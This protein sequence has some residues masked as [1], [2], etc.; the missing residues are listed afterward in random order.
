[1][2]QERKADDRHDC[3]CGTQDCVLHGRGRRGK[4][5]EGRTRGSA[6]T[7]HAVGLRRGWWVKGAKAGSK[8]GRRLKSLPH[9]SSRPLRWIAQSGGPR[10]QSWRRRALGNPGQVVS[11]RLCRRDR[12]HGKPGGMLH[13]VAR[14]IGLNRGRWVKGAKAGSKAGRRLESLPHK[15]NLRCSRRGRPTT[16]TTAG[17]ARKTACSTGAARGHGELS[18][19]APAIPRFR[20]AACGDG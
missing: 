2:Q 6:P 14:A 3:R 7:G 13:L 8:A 18:G 12:R 9:K 4:R 11:A 19:A 10:R 5:S 16:G 20:A 1:M 17:V 15:N